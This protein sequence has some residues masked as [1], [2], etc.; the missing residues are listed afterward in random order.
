MKWISTEI[1]PGF[2][3]VL[4]RSISFGLSHHTAS[5]IKNSLLCVRALTEA[6]LEQRPAARIILAADVQVYV[7]VPFN[8]NV[9]IFFHI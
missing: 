4:I 8:I 5:A 7:F 3:Q 9:F 1:N 6:K 2:M